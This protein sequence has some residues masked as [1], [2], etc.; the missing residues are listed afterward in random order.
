[1]P[2]RDQTGPLGFG[3]MTGHRAG[4][5]AGFDAPELAN[6]TPGYRTQ[7]GYRRFGG[8]GGGW[9]HGYHA[10]SQPGWGRAGFAHPGRELEMAGLEN[11]AEWL[12]NQLE[13][14]KRRIEELGR[15][16]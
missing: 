4:Y 6:P 5:C 9:R 15:K 3:P 7:F 8:R 13:A 14:I 2:G 10:T 11:E 16:D 1:M 12:K